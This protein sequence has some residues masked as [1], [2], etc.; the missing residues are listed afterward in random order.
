VK[1]YKVGILG[2]GFI[3]KVHAFGYATLPFYY[4]PV[5][6]SARI[7]HVVTGRIETAEKG[8]QLVGADVAATDY[9]AVTENPAIDIVH[10]C[11]PNHLHK[12]ALLSAMRHQKHLYCDKPLVATMAE[13]REIRAA[14]PPYHGTAQMTLQNRFF[15]ATMRARQ[16][17]DEGALGKILQFRACYLHGGSADPNAPLKWK[18]SA[19]AGGGVIADLASHVLDLVDWLAGPIRR[20]TAATQ[21]A[22]PDRPSPSDPARRLS[23]DAEDSVM[24]L[25]Q[26]ESGALGTIEATKI[27]SGTEDEIRLEI[28]GSRGALR[29][30]G[31]DPH[32]LEMY[33]ATA[34]DRPQGGARGWTRIDAGQR[35]PQPASGF[36]SPKASIGWIRSHVACLANFLEAVAQGRPAV[37][38]LEQGIAVQHL[39]DCVLRSAAGKCWVET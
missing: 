35:Y 39:M 36:P 33:D 29:I 18:L 17:V 28:H 6:L 2:F 19:A 20:L 7:T 9:R 37:P 32:H 38:G 12:D 21:I 13:A 15:P 34:A 11:T 14:L 23:V 31:M 26:L 4:D 8:R 10:I 30:N 24:L 16:L 5:P 1:T 27:A 3:G 22:Y 25:A